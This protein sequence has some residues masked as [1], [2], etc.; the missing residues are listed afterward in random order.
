[1]EGSLSDKKQAI[2]NSSSCFYEDRDVK[3]F[4]KKLKKKLIFE[5]CFPSIVN[6]EIDKIAGKELI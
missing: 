3:E 2:E 6:R 4:I 5:G 1:M